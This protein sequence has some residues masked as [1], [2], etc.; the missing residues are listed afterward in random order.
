MQPDAADGIELRLAVETKRFTERLASDSGR[1]GNVAD[2][3]RGQCRRGEASGP[4]AL[5]SRMSVKLGGD[6]VLVVEA[7][8]SVK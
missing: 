3:V 2:A 5:V 1:F 6:C 7:L 8:S 4:G